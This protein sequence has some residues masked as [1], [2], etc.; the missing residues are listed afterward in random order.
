MPS[1]ARP[2]PPL[3][4]SASPRPSKGG[5]ARLCPQAHP[6]RHKGQ[7]DRTVLTAVGPVT[8]RRCYF[9]CPACGQGD[10]G[11]DRILGLD[12]YVT[13]GACR[14]ACLLGVQQSFAAAQRALAE[15]AGWELD[16]NTIRQLCH[17]TAAAATAT[18]PE[19]A[20]AEAFAQAAGD[21]E[22]Q[23]DAGK[24]NTAAGWRDV[25]VAVFARRPRG[26]PTTAAQW[27]ERDLPAPAVRSVVAAVEEAAAFGQR[28]AAEAG[29]LRL[30]G[31]GPLSVLGDGAEWVWNLAEQHFPG[32]R[33][34]LDIYHGAGYIAGGA[35]AVFGEGSAEALAQAARGRLRLLADGYWGVTEWV[36]EITGAMPAGGDG[37]ALGGLL[38]YFA[39]HQER[40]GYALR[41]R[42]GQSIGS[43]L[44]EG[45]IKQLVNRRLKQTGA[46]WKVEH[47]GPLVELGALAAGP[48]WQDFWDRN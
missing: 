18:R 20:T 2:S 10:F 22:L 15:V 40:L 35:K 26:A 44:V 8:L 6:G 25:K 14:M 42:R 13:A 4:S 12:G 7:H 19:R 33:G 11:A 36:G 5:A 1:C 32:A 21:P 37:A 16:D 43:G 29:R 48:E 46:R 30:T 23:I 45:S 9:A 28:C 34:L 31:P 17:A 41:L 39:G 27:D 47:V 3:C 38:N 24:V